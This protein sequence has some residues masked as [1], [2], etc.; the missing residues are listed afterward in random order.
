VFARTHRL[1]RTQ[2]VEDL[3]HGSV[4]IVPISDGETND[5]RVKGPDMRQVAEIVEP[6]GARPKE[7]AIFQRP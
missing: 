2:P 4:V 3:P 1:D 6:F 7:F 5:P